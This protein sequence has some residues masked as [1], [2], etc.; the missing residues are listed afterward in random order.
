MVV[1]SRFKSRWVKT[2]THHG[3]GMHCLTNRPTENR[4]AIPTVPTTAIQAVTCRSSA[5]SMGKEVSGADVS[6]LPRIEGE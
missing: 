6:G 3:E 1:F 4:V 2:E 5:E